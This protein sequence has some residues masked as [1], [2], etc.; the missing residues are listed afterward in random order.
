MLQVQGDGGRLN[1]MLP[2]PAANN[3]KAIASFCAL[4]Y[5]ENM[6][7]AAHAP[8]NLGSLSWLD[9]TSMIHPCTCS[10]GCAAYMHKTNQ[11]VRN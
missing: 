1:K 4:G 10:T 8:I 5:V 7:F 11:T 2:S 3:S 9:K 6:K